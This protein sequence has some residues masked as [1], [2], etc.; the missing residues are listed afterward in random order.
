MGDFA[1]IHSVIIAHE[2][3]IWDTLGSRQGT[4]VP[5][6][7]LKNSA[8][9]SSKV[10]KTTSKKSSLAKTN[11]SVNGKKKPAIDFFKNDKL[12]KRIDNILNSDDDDDDEPSITSENNKNDE[13]QHIIDKA[14]ESPEH[15]FQKMS[16]EHD[17]EDSTPSVEELRALGKQRNYL[18][19]ID[20]KDI[21]RRTRKLLPSI[22]A[23]FRDTLG[24]GKTGAKQCNVINEVIEFASKYSG[25]YIN[26]Q[27]VSNHEKL[28]MFGYYG[29]EGGQDV[30]ATV[31]KQELGQDIR[32]CLKR[33]EIPW[34]SKFL[35]METIVRVALAPEVV[36]R[37][38]MEDQNVDYSEA[39][40]IMVES[41][42]YGRDVIDASF[43]PELESD[44]D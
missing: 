5:K 44:V 27:T 35:D 41:E 10:K 22:K 38:I 26:V 36:I 8:N 33:T 4:F 2:M 16:N 39:F 24:E 25:A 32:D 14:L 42:T 30:V 19:T 7:S 40:R 17:D 13:L 1:G 43:R 9:S 31:L 34:L 21:R 28:Y 20:K 11:S 12:E 6:S 18:G 23:L 3:G 15:S 37:L 29:T